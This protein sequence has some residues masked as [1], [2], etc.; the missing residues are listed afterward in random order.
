MA[1]VSTKG[2]LRDRT[3]GQLSCKPGQLPS[4][5]IVAS[6]ANNTFLPVGR[7]EEV[8]PKK[9]L[10][11]MSTVLLPGDRIRREGPGKW[12]LSELPMEA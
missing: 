12:S 2:P 11:G 10:A 5:R 8:S 3:L 1:E 7:L 4:G 6:C 9:G